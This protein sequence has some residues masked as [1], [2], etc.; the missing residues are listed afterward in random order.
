MRKFEAII[1]YIG[2][3][4]VVFGLSYFA[5]IAIISH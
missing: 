5:G 2:S 3:A 4:L 1:P